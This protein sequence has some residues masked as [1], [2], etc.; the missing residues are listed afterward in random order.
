VA[1]ADEDTKGKIETMELPAPAPVA[2]WW[3][4][5]K[6]LVDPWIEG[7]TAEE[8]D[9]VD[10]LIPLPSTDNLAHKNRVESI[11]ESHN[12]LSRF[13]AKELKIL[14]SLKRNTSAKAWSLRED[15]VVLT[16]QLC[17]K[18]IADL[19]G[20]RNKEAVKKRL[21]LLRSRG[22]NKRP[23]DPPPTTATS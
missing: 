6:D 23:P 4:E 22:L 2:K 8:F 21:Q 17:N 16:L 11:R 18:E 20:D 10:E 1:V 12:L 9:S 7:E 14:T 19:L 5:A 15:L 13:T 3:E